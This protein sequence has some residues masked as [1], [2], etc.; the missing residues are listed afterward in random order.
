MDK[1]QIKGLLSPLLERFRLKNISRLI[2]GK[3][4][5]DCGCGRAT[6]RDYIAKEIYYAGI[7]KDKN[8]DIPKGIK[9]YY[10]DL[11]KEFSIK[12]KFD[13]I[14]LS[15]VIEHLKNPEKTLLKLRSLLTKDGQIIITTSIPIR[16]KFHALTSML[17][18]TDKEAEEEH[19]QLLSK[20]NLL[21]LAKK[22]G[23][24]VKAYK[25]TEL[26]TKQNIILR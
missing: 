25:K 18:L 9:V 16:Y 22:T 10:L 13:N 21:E 26:W 23:L 19:Q 5:L 6:L 7:E 24:K 20:K 3:S 15:E 17:R 2:R 14:V 11:D 8:I 1:G 12:E 4:V